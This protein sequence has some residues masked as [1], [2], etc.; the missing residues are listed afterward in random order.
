MWI[1]ILS[2]RSTRPSIHGS[3]EMK[4]DKTRDDM[5]RN[6]AGAEQEGCHNFLVG[7]TD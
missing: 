5:A 7:G 3:L 1:K 4:T 6:G 2:S